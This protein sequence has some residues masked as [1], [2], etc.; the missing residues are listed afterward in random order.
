MLFSLLSVTRL[1]FGVIIVVYFIVHFIVPRELTRSWILGPRARRTRRPE[2]IRIFVLLY[3][4][5]TRL[6]VDTV[7]TG[8]LSES[9][10]V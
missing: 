2:E 5:A 8:G 4:L 1:L 6:V 9:A 10:S 3:I 7:D